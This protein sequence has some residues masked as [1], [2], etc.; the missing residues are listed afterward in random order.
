MK[1]LHEQDRTAIYKQFAEKGYTLGC[2]IGVYKGENAKVMLDIIPNLKLYLVDA[3]RKYSYIKRK[4]GNRWKWDQSSM[5]RVRAMALKRLAKSNVMWLM[6]PSTEAVRAIND[7]VFDFVYIDSDHRFDYVMHDLLMW[8]EKVR[9]G[10]C[11][12]GHDYGIRSVKK[13]VKAYAES[14]ELPLT[15]TDKAAEQRQSKTTVS[16][17]MTKE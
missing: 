11:I 16:W 12:S 10:G 14:H 6:L 7:I 13:A 15:I 2:E 1:T 3:Y 5:D 4:K 17:M 8:G 9:P